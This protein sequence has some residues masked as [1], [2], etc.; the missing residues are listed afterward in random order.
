MARR[1]SKCLGQDADE[2]KRQLGPRETPRG[3]NVDR[4]TLYQLVYVR[5]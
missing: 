1:V 4:V 2:T 3:N 5:S